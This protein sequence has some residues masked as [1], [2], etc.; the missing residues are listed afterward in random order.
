[1]CK[2]LVAT[3]IATMEYEISEPHLP[4]PGVFTAKLAEDERRA[5]SF[6]V[7]RERSDKTWRVGMQLSECG[8]GKTRMMLACIARNGGITVVVTLPTLVNQWRNQ[9]AEMIP[10]LASS[11][12][13]VDYE[14]IKQ[15]SQPWDRLVLDDAHSIGEV[16][17]RRL[18]PYVNDVRD[19]AFV[20]LMT[21]I[22][23]AYMYTTTLPFLFAGVG[24]Q[25]RGDDSV[26][27]T[28]TSA[29]SQTKRDVPLSDFLVGVSVR[30]TLPPRVDLA[31]TTE[32]LE[33]G[34][35][36]QGLYRDALAE[37]SRRMRHPV[38]DH[39]EAFDALRV[40]LALGVG[41]GRCVATTAGVEGWLEAHGRCHTEAFRRS[42][43]ADLNGEGEKT[44]TVCLVSGSCV[45]G[46]RVLPCG[47]YYCEDCT[48][49]LKRCPMC[50]APLVG[51]QPCILSSSGLDVGVR[52]RR[53]ETLISEIRVGAPTA[54]I[55]V[56]SG[57]SEAAQLIRDALRASRL[58]NMDA[59]IAD[60]IAKIRRG[61]GGVVVSSVP[62]IRGLNLPI[63]VSH[64][65][66]TEPQ[67]DCITDIL[68]HIHGVTG[69][70]IHVTTLVL[71]GT[72]EEQF[73]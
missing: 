11:V 1:M 67:I 60:E 36:G 27:V 6:M 69:S 4:P 72:I 32:F 58:V 17:L 37:S 55:L 53:V 64:I 47:H 2:Y 73:T 61:G 9:I 50:R 52:I 5:V 8:S 43:V 21:G 57:F 19:D 71:R 46:F 7:Q 14:S 44:C 54:S 31:M 59:V 15:L 70:K 16:V 28:T 40:H 30:V 3:A 29:T 51:V 26:H 13:V 12:S 63:F 23:T 66:V 65:I 24:V 41:R 56:L 20:W 22:P 68:S 34:P 45:D 48:R 62:S 33:L 38:V 35:M 42:V 18:R 10:T 39:N 49:R 25:T